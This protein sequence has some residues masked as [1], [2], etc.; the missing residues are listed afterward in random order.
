MGLGHERAVHGSS[1]KIRENN[2]AQGFT[3][4]SKREPQG[5]YSKT[6]LL[7]TLNLQLENNHERRDHRWGLA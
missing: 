1:A 6:Q 2:H 3:V 4:V 5:P 7:K